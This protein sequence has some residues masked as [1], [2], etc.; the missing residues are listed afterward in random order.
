MKAWIIESFDGIDKARLAEVPDPRPAAGEALLKVR[1]AALNPADA[2]LAQGQYPAKPPL[3][4]ILGRDG[5]GQIVELGAGVSSLRVGQKQVVLRGEVGI[6]RW[7]TLAQLVSVPVGSLVDVPQ[8]WTDQQ[9]AG[10]TLVYLT[11][12]QAITQWPDLPQQA[13]ILISGASGG[14][15]V[16]STQ[17]APAMGHTVVGLSRDPVKRQKLKSLG[18]HHVLD[19]TDPQWRTTL[20]ALLGERR[21]DLV[22]DN[23]GG[24][25]FPELLAT[26][27]D[28]G[29]VSVVGRLA[30]PVPQFNTASLL[31]RRI[32]IGGVAV[33]AYTN[34]EARQAWDQILMLLSRI[35]AR[36]LVDRVFAFDQL[37]EAFAYLARGPMGKV[38]LAVGE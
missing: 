20:K 4:H 11:A 38:L 25:L 9:A 37:P 24:S 16:A 10:A 35:N 28:R 27:A 26:L 30:G 36:P 29:R 5:M 34:A 18:M 22:I 14:V 32:R 7:G 6:T 17:L 3:P 19:P 1:F 13:V 8:G 33:G 2:Y 15:G 21:V 12:Y 23:V 31:F